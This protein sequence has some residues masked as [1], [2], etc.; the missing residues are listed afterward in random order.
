MHKNIILLQQILKRHK[1]KKVRDELTPELGSTEVQR[2]EPVLKRAEPMLNQTFHYEISMLEYFCAQFRDA[3]SSL[4]AP[5]T[6]KCEFEDAHFR[7][8][9]SCSPSGQAGARQL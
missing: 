8:I 9:L 5:S 3:H 1:N 6:P 2:A 4:S 7:F